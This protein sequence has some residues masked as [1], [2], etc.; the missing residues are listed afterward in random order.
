[1]HR[2]DFEQDVVFYKFVKPQTPSPDAEGSMKRPHWRRGHFR[3]Q[4]CGAGRAER[5]LVFVRPCF[6]NAD[7]FHGDKADTE[8]RIVAKAWVQVSSTG[9]AGIIC[10]PGTTSFG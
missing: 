1:M 9:Y 10:P 3:R 5:R 4:L 2:I 8:Y 7:H 6:I